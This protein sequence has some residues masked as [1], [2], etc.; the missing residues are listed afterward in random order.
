MTDEYAIRNT[1]DVIRAGGSGKHL[2][3]FT[4]I[5]LPS[6]LGQLLEQKTKDYNPLGDAVRLVNFKT[7]HF[8]LHFFSSISQEKLKEL[9]ETTELVTRGVNGF[10]LE[11]D[12][13]GFF[14]SAR[15]PRV[16]WW[17][18]RRSEALLSLHKRLDGAYSAK[19]LP[20]EKREYIPHLTIGRIKKPV[21][22][23]EDEKKRLSRKWR[24]AGEG[25]EVSELKLF[26]SPAGPEGYE[27]LKV[28]PLRSEF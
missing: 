12:E 13:P 10:S 27:T 8:T 6:G 28:F 16:F 20:L 9:I 15:N 17:G 5:Q 7:I 25:F 14:P 2:R 21:I 4:A 26:K 11:F 24:L 1:H 18:L 22:L 3:V 23:N 19:D